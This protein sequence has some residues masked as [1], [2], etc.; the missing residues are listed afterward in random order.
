MKPDE[1]HKIVY[2]MLI[3]GRKQKDELLC[4]LERYGAVL[5]N[6]IYGHGT[7]KPSA[8][9]SLLGLVPEENKAIISC[10]LAHEKRDA[11]MQM[12]VDEFDFEKPNTGIAFSFPIDQISF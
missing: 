8:L 1:T 2:L 6:T 5:A 3:A 12:L 11:V 7:I 9:D 10:I 4:A